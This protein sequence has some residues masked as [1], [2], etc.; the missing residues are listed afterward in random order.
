MAMSLDLIV[1]LAVVFGPMALILA[2]IV[3]T[4][5]PVSQAHPARKPDVP[6]EQGLRWPI[7]VASVPRV[8]SGAQHAQRRLRSMHERNLRHG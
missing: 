8:P 7:D 4:A 5:D 3:R 1:A 2:L 6:G